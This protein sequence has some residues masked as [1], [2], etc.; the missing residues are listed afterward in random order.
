MA[1]DFAAAYRLSGR[2]A[3]I[4]GGAA[5]IGFASARLLAA[6]GAKVAIVD[7][8]EAELAKASRA[9]AAEGFDVAAYAG[10]VT[11]EASVEAFVDRI[12][13]ECG[14]VDLLVNN[15]G[16]GSHIHPEK[17]ELQEWRRV[18][19]LNLT[20]Q[21]LVARAVGRRL[22]AAKRKG[23][24]V[25][26]SS[27]GGSSALGRGNFAYSVAKAGVLQLTRELAAEWAGA[28]IRVNAVQPCQ[29]GTASFN[30]FVSEES[31]ELLAR[32]LRGIPLGR[33]AVAE[34]IAS[35]VHFLSSDAASMIT[36]VALPVDG[37]NL[38]LNAGGNSR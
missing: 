33:L 24:I 20:G 1:I 8:R 26:L 38:A 29:V 35:A 2:V 18:V 37:G 27:I 17:L 6:A 32:M 10:D 9:L 11:D 16:G 12:G 3:L 25:N 34:D 13:R 28:G 31:K 5:G 4:T 23:S 21:F 15:A 22:L 7:I 19:E 14:V 36:G 30:A